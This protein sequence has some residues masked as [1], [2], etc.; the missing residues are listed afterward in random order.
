MEDP[1]QRLLI[2]LDPLTNMAATDNSYFLM[3]DF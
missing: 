1:L 3:V 2:F